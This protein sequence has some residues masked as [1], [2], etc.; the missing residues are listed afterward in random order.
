MARIKI[1]NFIKLQIP[2]VFLFVSLTTLCLFL[3]KLN[4][5]KTVIAIAKPGTSCEDAIKNLTS[6][7]KTLGTALAGKT[8]S[9]PSISTV[10]PALNKSFT[11]SVDI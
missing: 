11:R 10:L 8:V 5:I 2:I 6:V 3:G 1:L 4:L 7:Y 9:I